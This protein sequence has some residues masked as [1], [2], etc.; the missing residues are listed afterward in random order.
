MTML[1]REPR[2]I[3]EWLQVLFP[4]LPLPIAFV[5]VMIA[6]IVGMFICAL[7]LHH[8]LEVNCLLNNCVEVVVRK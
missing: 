1:I 6:M 4:T 8:F 3:K 2:G 5:L 7:I